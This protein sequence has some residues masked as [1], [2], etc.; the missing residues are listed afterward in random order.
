MTVT[1]VPGHAL[2]AALAGTALAGTALGR[3]A[4]GRTALGRT[5]LALAVFGVCAHRRTLTVSPVR[6]G[7]GIP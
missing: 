3:T 5:A 2:A 7:T 6:A 1:A 4:L